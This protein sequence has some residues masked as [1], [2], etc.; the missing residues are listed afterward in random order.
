MLVIPQPRGWRGLN[1]YGL[2]ATY[3]QP[4]FLLSAQYITTD[5]AHGDYAGDGYSV[6]GE[7]RITPKWNAIGR[8]DL[9]ELDEGSIEKKRAIAGV[10]YRYNKYVEFI[11][12]YLKEKKTGDEAKDS[13]MLTA[14]INW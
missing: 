9:F 1:W 3:N 5:E 6:N 14:E 2:N 10:S 13:I 4:A 7:Y 12:N 8:Y 11:A